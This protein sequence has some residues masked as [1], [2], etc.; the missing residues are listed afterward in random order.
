MGTG[1]VNDLVSVDYN[2]PAMINAL[3]AIQIINMV[4]GLLLPAVIYVWLINGDTRPYLKLTLFPGWLL[5]LL[6]ALLILTAQPFISYTNDLNGGLHLPA[7]MSG[8]ESWMQDMEH[9]AQVLTDAFLATTSIPGLLLNLFMIALLPAITEEIVFRGV[10]AQLFR[11]WTRSNHWAIFISSLV[12]A[13][14][15]L[16]FYG[17]LPRFLLGM[18]LGYLFFWSGSLWVPIIAHFTNNLLSVMV[19][20]LYR[21]G[22]LSISADQFGFSDNVLVVMLS[23]MVTMAL[24]FYI[25][26]RRVKVQDTSSWDR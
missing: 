1:F 23:F 7:F 6:T 19:E 22:L 4:G 17:F 11:D 12:F 15:H 20:F 2:N 9:Q 8:L 10:L 3:K 26:R 18:S 16:Q 21:K 5:M 24:L 13:G 25:Y 14:I